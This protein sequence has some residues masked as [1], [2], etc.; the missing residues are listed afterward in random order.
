[1]QYAPAESNSAWSWLD[2][3]SSSYIWKPP[4][5]TK[6]ACELSSQKKAAKPKFSEMEQGQSK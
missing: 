5:Q 2:R 6:K 1:M 3:W 4:M